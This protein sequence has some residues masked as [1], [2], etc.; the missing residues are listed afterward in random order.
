MVDAVI[1][2]ALAA[3]QDAPPEVFGRE[4]PAP[5]PR[6]F[7][8]S[9]LAIAAAAVLVF[10]VGSVAS[11]L[12]WR[13]LHVELPVTHEPVTS[14]RPAVRLPPAPAPEPPQD[15]V[16]PPAIV[17]A[18]PPPPARPMRRKRPVKVALAPWDVDVPAPAT[19][20]V[21]VVPENLPPADLLALANE[22]RTRRDWS[23]A[24][25][26]YAAVVS[27]FR[28]ADAAVVA[29]VASAALHLQHLGDPAGALRGYQRALGARPSGPVAEE[30]RWGVAE[31]R[32]SL[33]E[34]DA[35][36]QALRDFVDH[37]PDSALAP[38]ASRRLARLTR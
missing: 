13:L 37:H 36:I 15:V 38:A 9:S 1:D 4:A 5:A 31:A 6:R 16:V 29:E 17:E 24:D 20:P 3:P 8:W 26:Y 28:G 22:R 14:P 30:A 18:H 21:L 32:R 27:R 2:A 19:A 7:R 25:A 33:G 35:E 10:S 23:G 11:A 34:T 12:A